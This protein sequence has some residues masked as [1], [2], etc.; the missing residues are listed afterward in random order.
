ML[1]DDLGLLRPAKL[2]QETGV[3]ERSGLI[4][5]LKGVGIPQVEL[6][7]LQVALSQVKASHVTHHLRVTLVSFRLLLQVLLRL[8][9]IVSQEFLFVC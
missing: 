3:S 8:G 1:K 6:C 7:L 4:I 5:E 2:A 9:W